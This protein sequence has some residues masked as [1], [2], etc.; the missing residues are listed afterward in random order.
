MNIILFGPPGS[1]KGTQSRFIINNFN[2]KLIS[3][4]DILR[5]Y[6]LKNFYI[7]NILS[8]G[9]LISNDIILDIVK[10]FIK[11]NY[12]KYGYLFDGFPRNIIQANSFNFLKIDCVIELRIDEKIVFQRLLGRR[13]HLNSGRVY[14]LLNNPPKNY[15]LD[16]VTGEKIVRREDDSNCRI[17]KKRLSIYYYELIYLRCFYKEKFYNYKK[18]NCYY[19]INANNDIKSISFKIINFIK[20]IL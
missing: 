2:L 9:I 3:L 19:V 7:K 17:I 5:K 11:N 4:G 20:K 1:G 16:D 12:S 15:G 6:S 13:I 14:H 8:L 18:N 10:D